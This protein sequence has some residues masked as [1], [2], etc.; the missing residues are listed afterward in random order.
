MVSGTNARA[1]WVGCA[2]GPG[3]VPAPSPRV[4]TS[5]GTA[6][7]ENRKHA[8]APRRRSSHPDAP[9]RAVRATSALTHCPYCSLQCGISMVAGDRPGFGPGARVL[10]E[11]PE[12][13]P[14]GEVT[15]TLLPLPSSRG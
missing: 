11:G 12:E 4:L 10:S 9:Y 15:A 3:P 2:I 14:S 8:Y 13:L 1:L 5:V 6:C 7:E